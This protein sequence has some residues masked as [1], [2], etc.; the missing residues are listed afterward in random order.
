[1]NMKREI[2]FNK[3]ENYIEP[4]NKISYHINCDNKRKYYRKYQCVMI[5]NGSKFE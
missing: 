4:G 1:M 3:F 5:N 2:N